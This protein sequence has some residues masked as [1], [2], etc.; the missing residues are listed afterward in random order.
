MY[1]FIM[2]NACIHFKQHKTSSS[3][4]AEQPL[5]VRLPLQA[6]VRLRARIWLLD[7]KASKTVTDIDTDAHTITHIITHTLTIRIETH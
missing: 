6:K 7:G 2:T 3:F 5:S 4:A 1:P